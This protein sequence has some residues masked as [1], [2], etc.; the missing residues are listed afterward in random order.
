MPESRLSQ[1]EFNALRELDTGTVSNSIRTF[2]PGLRNTAFANSRVRGLVEDLS[3]M[4]GS[5]MTARARSQEPPV[6]K[7]TVHDRSE[8][9][10][11]IL[12]VPAP[13][14]A[15]AEDMDEPPNRGAFKRDGNAAIRQALGGTGVISNNAVR[16]LT[17]VLETGFH[18]FSRTCCRLRT[19]PSLRLD[20]EN[21]AAW[22]CTL[23][24][25]LHGDRCGTSSHKFQPSPRPLS[26]REASV[27]LYA[28]QVRFHR[29]KAMNVHHSFRMK[30]DSIE[31]TLEAP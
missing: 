16:E 8:W 23:G 6:D 29:P 13:R 4:V 7:K 9:R 25:S 24:D 11:R 21:R 1:S 31:Q 20:R 10:E 2:K 26:G 18:Y 27:Y 22:K 19:R 17:R 5:A 12:A 3:P 30:R 15:V 14:L 28:G